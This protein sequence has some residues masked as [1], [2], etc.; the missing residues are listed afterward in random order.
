M[1]EFGI[2]YQSGYNLSACGNAIQ[3]L[4][5]I[6]PNVKIDLIEDGSDLYS[7]IA[8]FFK[9]NY[10]RINQNG[11][12]IRPVYDLNTLKSWFSRINYSCENYLKE[13]EYIV[14]YEDDVWC[15]RKVNVYPT[16]DLEGHSESLYNE[17]LYQFLKN[18]FNVKDESRS[19]NS[20]LG[21]LQGYQ[22]AGGTIFKRTSFM[23]SYLNLS[24]IDY[25]TIGN[26][27]SRVCNWCDAGLSFLFQYCGFKTGVWE[28]LGQPWNYKRKNGVAFL[29]NYKK[30]Y[31]NDRF[32]LPIKL[33]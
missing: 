4:I 27:D 2:W 14:Y 11:N 19:K 21:S 3:K 7:G 29:H 15:I 33:L 28:D 18:R 8:R 32:V 16:M 22:A 23:Q 25:K 5:S 20:L 24:T 12:R 10:T 17:G 6:Y 30:H 13:C 31:N 1:E 9:C 26:L